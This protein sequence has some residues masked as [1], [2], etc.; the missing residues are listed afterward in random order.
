MKK[1]ILISILCLLGGIVVQAQTSQN[2]KEKQEVVK[3]KNGHRVRGKIVTYAPLDSL[4]I[5][6]DDGTLQ[7]IYWDNIKQ[8]TKEDWQPQQTLGSDFTPGKGPQRG[9]RGFVDLEYYLS[10]DEMSK[11]HIGFSTTHGYQF[12]PW[13]FIGAGVGM[14]YI[15]KKH[16]KA[17]PFD[18]YS[19]VPSSIYGDYVAAVNAYMSKK[20]DFYIFPVFADIRLDLLKSRFSPFLDCR[21][22]Y[23]FGG[24]AFGMMLN[25]SLGCRVGLTDR[26]AINATI[27]YSM[28]STDIV[29]FSYE[30][31]AIWHHEAGNWQNNP[32][33]CLSFKLGVEF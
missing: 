16:L 32:Y 7:T 6:E 27:G 24:K 5:Q 13:L 29:A 11:D 17:P 28:Q 10:V 21:V 3:L 20:S 14:R 4:V 22:G 19:S 2:K 8:I 9:Y 12:K 25:P 31:S 23:T 15:H 26:L 33:H 30:K 1:I 18:I